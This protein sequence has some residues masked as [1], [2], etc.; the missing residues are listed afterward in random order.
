LFLFSV[1]FKKKKKK[2]EEKQQF[3]NKINMIGLNCNSN[4]Y[5]KTK[6]KKKEA[7]LSN[8]FNINK[9]RTRIEK[10]EFLFS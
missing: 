2:A 4:F 7:L 10:I 1:K 5:L 8:R 3:V 6:K 9:K